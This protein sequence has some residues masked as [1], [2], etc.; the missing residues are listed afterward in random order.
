MTEIYSHENCEYYIEK[1]DFC[2]RFKESNMSE[3]TRLC[4]CSI[5]NGDFK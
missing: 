2:F 4:E 3:R 1:Y 5:R